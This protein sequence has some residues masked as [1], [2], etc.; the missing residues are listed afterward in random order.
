VTSDV[1]AFTTKRQAGW[2][3]WSGRLGHAWKTVSTAAP[4]LVRCTF[5]LLGMLIENQEEGGSKTEKKDEVELHVKE[6]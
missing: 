4:V 3:S 5:I 6:R 2:K 1:I